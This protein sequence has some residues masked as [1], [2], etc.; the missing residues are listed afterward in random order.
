M[1]GIVSDRWHMRDTILW[2][3]I[4]MT[5]AIPAGARD[6][7]LLGRAN[8]VVYFSSRTP[9]SIDEGPMGEAV[10]AASA[11]ENPSPLRVDYPLDDTILP[12]DLAAP[13]FVWSDPAP[14]T[15]VWLIDLA[16][17]TD[18]VYTLTEGSAPARAP[19]DDP[20]SVSPAVA[21]YQPPTPVVPVRRWRP[22]PQAWDQIKG[23]WGR[24]AAVVTI[25]GFASSQ[26]GQA[27]SQGHVRLNLS[28]DPVGAPIFFRD[29]PLP[30]RHALANLDS[31][32]WRLGEVSAYESRTLLTGMKVCG[33]CHSFTP[34]GK[35][36][37]MDV[38][39]G[40]D[41]GSYVIADIRP[42]TVLSKDKVIS[43]SDYLRDDKELTFGLL[44]QISPDGRHVVSTVKDRSVFAS[45]DD[46]YYSQRFFPVL[47]ILV[48]YDRQT[49]RFFPLAGAD[50]RRYVQ[51]NPVWSPDGKTILFAYAPAY[52]LAGLK[53]PASAVVERE[54]VSEFFEG[55]KKFRYD[56]FRIDFNNGQGGRPTPV[57]GA[58]GNGKSNYFP[59]FS[60]DGRWI[61]FCQSDSFMLLQP[62]S[63]LYLMP[64]HGGPPRPMRCNFPGKMNSWHSWSPNGPWLVFASKADGPF[65]Q[66][67]LTHIDAEGNDSPAVLL[68]HLTASNRAANIP[69]FVNVDPR[70]FAEIRQE[71][72]DYYTYYRIGLGYEQRHE[73]AKAITEFRTVLNEQPNHVETLYL[74][75]S[76]LARLHRE[77]EAVPYAQKA[78]LLAPTSPM[79]HGLLGSLLYS[80]GQYREALVHLRVAHLANPDDVGIANNLAWLLA[81][82]PD[83]TCRNGQEALRLAEWA[84]KATDYK[85]PPLLD[86]LAAAYA[87]MGRFEQ[88]V[89]TIRKAIE[90][91]RGSPKGSTQ[92]LDARLELYLAGTPCREPAAR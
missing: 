73:Y 54:E 1:T 69:E 90:I 6:R 48:V 85:S 87:E 83:A 66:L 52:K 5:L 7:L 21:A 78:V 80:V 17:G 58:S 88:A 3:A 51:S 30:F 12:P 38:D 24:G 26:P 47:G 92:T 45:M 44:S 19:D 42:L 57:P 28:E 22:N 70:G 86:S 27:S 50:D 65:T 15:D 81:T 10:R 34:D 40:S 20:R 64:A 41:K 16:F 33:N 43:W 18:H 23:L 2:T 31:I 60:P 13:T 39:Y 89:G 55:D 62:D 71:F 56:L 72:A 14:H 37:A 11:S 79:T 32:R 75:A 9:S 84:C 46:L 91:V 67:W 68:E 35:T 59:R 36:L 4:A 74:L 53:D 82:C 63:M 25:T 8:T 49:H 61:V 29:V 77:Q 76:C